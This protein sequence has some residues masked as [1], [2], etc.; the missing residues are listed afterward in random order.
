MS[1]PKNITPE[2]KAAWKIK[3]RERQRIFYQR[4]IARLREKNRQRARLHPEKSKEWALKNPEKRKEIAR[5]W[6]RK[7][8]ENNREEYLEKKKAYRILNKDRINKLARIRRRGADDY[9]Y[10]KWLESKADNRPYNIKHSEKNSAWARKNREKI[11]AANKTKRETN[12]QK[13]KD[14]NRQSYLK[15]KPR[16]Q[17]K[18]IKEIEQV[19]DK[20]VAD[21]LKVKRSTLIQF[22]DLIEAKR[23]QLKLSRELKQQTKQTKCTRTPETCNKSAT[24]SRRPLTPHG[25]T[26]L[27]S[28]EL[29]SWSTPWVKQLAQLLLKS[30]QLS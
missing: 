1:E 26:K 15:Y 24:T 5:N 28:L 20:Y 29:S 21:L 3:Q 17:S 6:M 9:K 13:Y 4:N 22:P 8:R 27:L 11:N 10:R 14:R 30:K 2:Q 18:L 16:I 25:L 7:Y 23:E 12:P 19:S